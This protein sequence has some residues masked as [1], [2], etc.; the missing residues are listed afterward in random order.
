MT[1]Y[2]LSDIPPETRQGTVRFISKSGNYGF[3]RDGASKVDLFFHKD[4][5]L[6]D[7][8]ELRKDDSVSF[9]AVPERRKDVSQFKA[10]EIVKEE[11]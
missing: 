5:V 11:A 7:F 9:L 6:T 1:G 4:E 8:T 3:I 2:V 10:I